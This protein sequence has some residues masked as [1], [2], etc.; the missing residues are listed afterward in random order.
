MGADDG[1]V[2]DADIQRHGERWTLSMSGGRSVT[3][4]GRGA[5]SQKDQV[6]VAVS[7]RL[8]ERLS[9]SIAVRGGRN[10]ELL[11]QAAGGGGQKL[12]YSRADLRLNWQLAERWS[13]AA[14][15]GGNMQKIDSQQH[16]AENYGA[17]LSIVWN[18][19]AHYL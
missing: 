18:G 19:Q 14:G 9:A 17:S 16:G 6:S 11:T 1:L 3:S 8:T 15:V 5:L 7:R 10:Q 2:F 4:T 12:N 13:L